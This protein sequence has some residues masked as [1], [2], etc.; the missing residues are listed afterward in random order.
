MK[1]AT[2]DEKR[3]V[4]YICE[5]KEA[6]IFLYKE[7]S[8]LRILKKFKK[9][10]V[11]DF[12]TNIPITDK[13][14]D[15]KR[16]KIEIISEMPELCKEIEPQSFIYSDEGKFIGYTMKIGKFNTLEKH[17]G[18]NDN[19]TKLE[20]LKQL[21]EKV[22]KL[23]EQG[24]YIGDFNPSNFG[25]TKDG[26]MLYDLDYLY[27]N[28][29]DFSFDCYGVHN[30]KSKRKDIENIDDYC[31]NYFT[32]SFLMNVVLN[33]VDYN[34]QNNGLPFKLR[35]K[36]NKELYKKLSS[37]EDGFQKKYFID[38]QKKGLLR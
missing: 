14:L 3:I 36:E 13:M 20:L 17:F 21:R 16:K 8:D 24:I 2:I 19:K 26:I 10:I 28:G 37:L 18:T 9:E 12:G 29:I 4:R 5:G 32:L 7:D 33:N 35:T 22:Q 31:F 6:D 30:Y 1:K 34:V 27:V 23:N 15:D 25:V 11:N 38:S